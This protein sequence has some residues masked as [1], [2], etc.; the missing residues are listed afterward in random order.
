MPNPAKNAIGQLSEAEIAR[1]RDEAVRRALN[2][3]PRPYKESKAGAKKTKAS[4]SDASSDK[5]R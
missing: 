5:K 2:T 4:A 3:P 1:R